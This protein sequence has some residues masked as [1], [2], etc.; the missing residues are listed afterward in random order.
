MTPDD[1]KPL[2]TASPFVRFYLNLSDGTSHEVADPAEA[3]FAPSGAVLLHESKGRR[4]LIALAHV[5]SISFPS[6]TGGGEAFF[7]QGRP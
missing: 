5:V 6:A 7:L 3:T 1:I 4:T 2:L